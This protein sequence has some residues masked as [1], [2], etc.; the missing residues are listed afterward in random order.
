MTHLNKLA[1]FLFIATT[2]T[3]SGAMEQEHSLKEGLQYLLNNSPDDAFLMVTESPEGAS[4]EFPIRYT[5]NT[6]FKETRWGHIVNADGEFLQIF[7]TD[8]EGNPIAP[9]LSTTVH[10]ITASPKMLCD[11]TPKATTSVK[12][13][14]INLAATD[15][16]DSRITAPFQVWGNYG[17]SHSINMNFTRILSVPATWNVVASPLDIN[18]VT[19]DPP[20]VTGFPIVFDINGRIASINGSVLAGN[21]TPPLSIHTHTQL[22]WWPYLITMDFGTIGDHTGIKCTGTISDV[23]TPPSD[24]GCPPLKYSRTSIDKYTGLLTAHLENG[25]TLIYGKIPVATIGTPKINLF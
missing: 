12:F 1:F 8:G 4:L 16:I 6:D 21:N 22:T 15:P 14:D 24:D 25:R 10:M 13:H 5:R 23:T 18:S 11:L 9:E 7:R 3:S 2:I 17:D 19:I 20:Y